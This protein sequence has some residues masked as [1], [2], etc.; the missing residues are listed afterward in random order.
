MPELL[1]ADELVA[2]I[3]VA[4]RRDGNVLV[5][6]AAAAQTLDHARALIQIDA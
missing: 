1:L 6:G 2:G 4:V 5:A 3:D